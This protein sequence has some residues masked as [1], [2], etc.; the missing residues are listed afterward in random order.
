MSTIEQETREAPQ[1]PCLH[2]GYH[3]PG[4]CPEANAVTLI[5]VTFI[6]P[7]GEDI[8]DMEAT[9]VVLI[10]D[11]VEQ[12]DIGGGGVLGVGTYLRVTAPDLVVAADALKRLADEIIH[13]VIDARQDRLDAEA[14]NCHCG[15]RLEADEEDCGSQLCRRR[16]AQ[17]RSS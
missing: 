3:Q 11:K 17:E 9:D 16:S 14:H 4:Q 7:N 6:W 2:G 12:I 8:T 10:G 13:A 1:R 15:V 5:P